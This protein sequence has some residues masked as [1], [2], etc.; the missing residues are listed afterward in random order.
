MSSYRIEIERID[1]SV[2]D[3]DLRFFVDDQ[4]RFATPCWE[5]AE[6]LIP[7][8]TYTGCST[9]TMASKGHKAVFLPDEQTGRRGIFIHPGSRPADSEGCIVADRQRVE[10]I[11]NTVPRDQRN[12][13]VIV[14]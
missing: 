4:Q 12:I 11:Y 9:T 1:R 2:C 6:K 13:V 5:D 10:E 7:A 3:G 14:S 8:K